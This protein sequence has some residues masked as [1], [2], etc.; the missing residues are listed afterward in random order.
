MTAG[1]KESCNSWCSGVAF[2]ALI[3][4][5]M[6][7]T[8]H[9]YSLC[10]D[11]TDG[12]ATRCAAAGWRDPLWTR[13]THPKQVPTAP[14]ALHAPLIM[15]VSQCC[16]MRRVCTAIERPVDHHLRGPGSATAQLLVTCACQCS[17]HGVRIG[18]D[19][20]LL[21]ALLVMRGGR[22]SVSHRLRS[23]ALGCLLCKGFK[24]EICSVFGHNHQAPAGPAR[25]ASALRISS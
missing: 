8:S 20:G 11:G 21:R 18:G 13:A 6:S 3:A 5:C 15:L 10:S 14:Q 23:V 1:T 4:P 19:A 16:K 17:Q 25:S 7:T 12:A 9:R 24:A 2:S 22:R